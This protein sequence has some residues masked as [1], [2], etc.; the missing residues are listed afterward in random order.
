MAIQAIPTHAC[1]VSLQRQT[2]PCHAH[3]RLACRVKPLRAS[4]GGRARQV[5]DM[6]FVRRMPSLRTS[7]VGCLLT[8]EHRVLARCRSLRPPP[9]RWQENL[10]ATQTDA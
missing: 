7:L 4:T 8:P 6:W 3:S 5:K 9:P 1:L 10:I 2:H